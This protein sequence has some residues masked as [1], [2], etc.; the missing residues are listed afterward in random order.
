MLHAIL[1]VRFPLVQT[2]HLWPRL[3]VNFSS[4]EY[5]SSPC[6]ILLNVLEKDALP[7]DV[8]YDIRQSAYLIALQVLCFSFR[9]LHFACSLYVR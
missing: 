5:E 9:H 7:S 8:D 3:V 6:R 4:V 2:H 1:Q